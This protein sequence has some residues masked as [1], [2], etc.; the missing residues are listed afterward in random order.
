MK[1]ITILSQE[2]WQNYNLTSLNKEE[3]VETNGGADIDPATG[4]LIL[5]GVITLL[6]GAFRFIKG[7]FS[8]CDDE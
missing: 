1:S 7:L 6:Y 2:D 4:A 8:K 5:V 3:Q